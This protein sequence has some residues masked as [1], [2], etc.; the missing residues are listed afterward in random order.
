M[1]YSDALKVLWPFV[2]FF[3]GCSSFDAKHTI[4]EKCCWIF[5]YLPIG[6]FCEIHSWKPN[7]ESDIYSLVPLTP[8]DMKNTKDESDIYSW[9]ALTSK[10]LFCLD[11]EH[12]GG[13]YFFC[14]V[15]EGNSVTLSADDENDR[16]MWVHKISQAT[17]QSH[18]PVAPQTIELG[19]PKTNSL[20][21]LMGDTDRARKYGLHD[22][23]SAD[24]NAVDQHSLF[25][26]LQYLT[27]E[28]R[29]NDY[30]SCLVREEIICFS[31]T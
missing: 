3:S 20:T 31:H 10:H 5:F 6:R 9:R 29:L 22:A 1:N 18:R 13:K 2:A 19:T 23:V 25:K 28:H 4:F 17:G 14:C 21:K 16:Q 8:K 27:L 12:E 15:K 11:E 30:C 26:K 24:P 7:G